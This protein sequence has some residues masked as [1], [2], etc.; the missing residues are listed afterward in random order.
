MVWVGYSHVAV[1][2][3]FVMQKVMA[4]ERKRKDLFISLVLVRTRT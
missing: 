2:L 3:M 1:I 4:S